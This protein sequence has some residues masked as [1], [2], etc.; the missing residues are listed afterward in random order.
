MASLEPVV[1]HPQL[2]Q[3]F[4]SAVSIETEREILVGGVKRRDY[5]PDR[6]VFEAV[7][8]AAGRSGIRV[9]LLDFKVPPPDPKHR[10]ALQQYAQ[11][12]RQLG[13]HDVVCVLYYFGTGQVEQF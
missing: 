1:K 12:F 7:P 8:G 9:T 11:L 2:A 3:Y 10:R 4:S 6:V 5:K 13:Y